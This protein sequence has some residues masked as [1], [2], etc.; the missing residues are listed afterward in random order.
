MSTVFG[1]TPMYLE[2]RIWITQAS[3]RLKFPLEEQ[4]CAGRVCWS[5]PLVFSCSCTPAHRF[6]SSGKLKCLI[7]PALPAPS[8][9]LKNVP[10]ALAEYNLEREYGWLFP[11]CSCT[12][13]YPAA[14]I[15][16]KAVTA[17]IIGKAIA[18]DHRHNS[19]SF[20]QGSL[21]SC[22]CHF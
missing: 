1:L 7:I 8:R 20:I 12:A 16:E 14:D 5:F 6:C 3:A 22:V 21:F 13:C 15:A 18:V 10:R 17:T 2:W 11:L 4:V 9:A 19:Q